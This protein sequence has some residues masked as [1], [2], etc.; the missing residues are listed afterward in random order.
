MSRAFLKKDGPA[1]GKAQTCPEYSNGPPPPFSPVS[2]KFMEYLAKW[3]IFSARFVQSSQNFRLPF[4]QKTEKLHL[5]QGRFTF[6]NIEVKTFTVRA[7]V[8][9]AH[10]V[11]VQNNAVFLSAKGGD[12]R[13]L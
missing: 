13:E 1:A 4:P 5:E 7:A 6:Y 10:S 3:R 12:H 9:P 2:L 11:F 8:W